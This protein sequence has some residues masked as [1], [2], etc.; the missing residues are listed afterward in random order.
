MKFEIRTTIGLGL[1]GFCVGM[2]T[3]LVVSEH[4]YVESRLDMLDAKIN[5]VN[6]K[7]NLNLN[8][9][10]PKSKKAENSKKETAKK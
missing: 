1:L 8:N 4:H 9:L 6:I 2:L 10:T 7:T 3:Y 5:F